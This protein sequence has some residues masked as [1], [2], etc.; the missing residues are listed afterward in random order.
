MV[1]RNMS[2][3]EI[4]SFSSRPEHHFNIIVSV[5]VWLKPGLHASRKDRK[6]MLENMIF[7]SFT[8]LK[9]WIGLFI[10]VMITREWSQ[11]LIFQTKYFI[12]DM[13]RSIDK[14]MF[15]NES[16]CV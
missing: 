1:W 2:F 4:K 6:H 8:K 7:F 9:N 13:F 12:F 5:T 16:D 15:C 14:N 11:V 3:D 10:V